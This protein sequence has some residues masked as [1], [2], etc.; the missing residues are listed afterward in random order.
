M[1]AQRFEA[2]FPGAKCVCLAGDFNEWRPE[3]RR[4]KRVRKDDDAFVALVDLP[5]GRH[6]YKFVVDG[7]WACCGH[8]PRTCNGL[9]SE[10]N[11]LVVEES[12]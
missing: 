11:V 6:E 7:E 12:C 4:M 3:G 8:T 9:G 1:A 10:N 5:P 2:E